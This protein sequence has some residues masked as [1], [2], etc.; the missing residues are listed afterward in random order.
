M[1]G[2]AG[3]ALGERRPRIAVAF[4]GGFSRSRRRSRSG[5]TV[6][7]RRTRECLPARYSS[8]GPRPDDRGSGQPG[9][10][11]TGLRPYDRRGMRYAPRR[12]RAGW[13]SGLDRSVQ[14]SP[15]HPSASPVPLGS[16]V[17][18]EAEAVHGPAGGSASKRKPVFLPFD[19]AAGEKESPPVIEV[20]KVRTARSART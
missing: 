20:G 12:L 14:R 16:F 9:A 2:I 7:R 5:S 11:R 19:P 15:E 4:R 1:L 10:A 6:R 3:V 8:L 18:A 13:P 17:S